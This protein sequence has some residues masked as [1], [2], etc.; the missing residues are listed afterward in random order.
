MAVITL[1]DMIDDALRK[2][3]VIREGQAPTAE[4]NRDAIITFNGLMAELQSDE[5]DV[6]DYPV[7][8]IADELELERE[9]EEP[10]RILFAR[11]LQTDHGLPPDV[12]LVAAANEALVF[13]ERSTFVRPDFSLSHVPQG[14]AKRTRFFYDINR[15]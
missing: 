6:G 1:G 5:I 11:R 9:H 2:A 12:S 4:Q 8:E 14:R 13:L 3:G 7:D 15:G 10:V